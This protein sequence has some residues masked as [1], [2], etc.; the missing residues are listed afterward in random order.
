MNRTTCFKV[1]FLSG[2]AILWGCTQDAT[3]HGAM[4]G[5]TAQVDTR[6]QPRNTSPTTVSNVGT[7]Q[8]TRR[9]T[10]NAHV[11]RQTN[12]D[13]VSETIIYEENETCTI[14]TVGRPLDEVMS[15]VRHILGHSPPTRP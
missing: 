6:Q 13:S 2:P 12:P 10:V 4:G 14:T 7:I 1:L 9:Y 8:K 5:Q 3:N 11:P 15:D